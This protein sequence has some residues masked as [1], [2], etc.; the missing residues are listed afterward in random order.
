[1]FPGLRFAVGESGEKAEGGERKFAVFGACVSLSRCS[2]LIALISCFMNCDPEED[3]VSGE[4]S[5]VMP[6]F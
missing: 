5:I 2:G 1:V 6:K 4:S 3:F